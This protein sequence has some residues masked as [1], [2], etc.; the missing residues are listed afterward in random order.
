AIPRSYALVLGI[1]NYKNLAAKDQLQFS[2]RDAESI[3]SIL[4]SPEGG[5]FHAE[6]VHKLTGPRATLA[7]MRHELEEWLPATARDGDR[8]LI[9]FAGHGFLYDGHAYLAPYD[10]DPHN[11]TGTGYPMDTLGSVIGSRMI[12]AARCFRSPPAATAS[13]PSRAPIGAAGMASSL[14][15]SSRDWRARPTSRTTAS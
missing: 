8:V 9:Y 13:A 7:N 6:N 12:S 11:I 15:M 10:L 14:T 1:A 5:N 3:Y 2:E 4:I